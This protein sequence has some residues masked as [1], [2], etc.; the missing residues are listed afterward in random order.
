[1]EAESEDKRIIVTGF[2][3]FQGVAENPTER[4]VQRLKNEVGTFLGPLHQKTAAI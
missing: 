3:K 2:G 1:M 4:L